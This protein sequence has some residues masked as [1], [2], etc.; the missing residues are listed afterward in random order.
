MSDMS[1]GS[2]VRALHVWCDDWRAAASQRDPLVLAVREDDGRGAVFPVIITGA[3]SPRADGG[4]VKVFGGVRGSAAGAVQVAVALVDRCV[5]Q[6]SEAAV[7]A[8]ETGHH[9]LKLH[10]RTWRRWAL[11]AV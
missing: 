2:H 9:M 10:A 6:V 7:R 4:E 5:D 3:P 11:L 1:H 8:V